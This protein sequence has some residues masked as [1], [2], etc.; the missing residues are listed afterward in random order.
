MG[1]SILT[2]RY[3]TSLQSAAA[4]EIGMLTGACSNVSSKLSKTIL[5][6]FKCVTL[7]NSLDSSLWIHL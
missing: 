3:N 5:L 1:S 7:T 4:D 6:F 2:K